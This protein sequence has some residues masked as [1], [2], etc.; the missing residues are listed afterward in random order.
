MKY[1]DYINFDAKTFTQTLSEFR[2]KLRAS[3]SDEK[4]RQTTNSLNVVDED[5]YDREN[6]KISER[7]KAFKF[8]EPINY[9]HNVTINAIFVRT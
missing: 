8:C 6:I 2:D 1:S 3:I 9:H 5:S 7:D 4:V